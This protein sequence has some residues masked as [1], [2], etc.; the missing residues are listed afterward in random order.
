MGRKRRDACGRGRS[1][2]EAVVAV[3]VGPSSESDTLTRGSTDQR[4]C[5]HGPFRFE[6]PHNTSTTSRTKDLTNISR[7]W[8]RNAA[9]I[10][11][12]WS[13]I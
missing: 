5:Q 12:S 11:H 13:K 7:R 8:K 2:E 3:A 9:S 4:K 1:A 6:Q 10:S